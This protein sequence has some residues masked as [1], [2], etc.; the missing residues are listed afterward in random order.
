MND[1]KIEPIPIPDPTT[2][3]TARPAPMTLAASK[4]HDVLSFAGYARSVQ[5][6][7]VVDVQACEDRE[8]IGLKERD[9]QLEPG[10]RRDKGERNDAK[11]TQRRNET[12]EDLEQGVPGEHVREQ[13]G[14]DRLIGRDKY[15]MISIGI[16]RGHS[17]TETPGGTKNVKKWTPCLTKP[18]IV[19]PTNTTAARAKVTMMWLVKVKL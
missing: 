10:E 17:A 12:G 13:P 15:E 9:H 6:Q 7:C 14:T 5:M 18:R 4:L 2:P 1:E 19:T 3:I 16:S 11:H 8:H